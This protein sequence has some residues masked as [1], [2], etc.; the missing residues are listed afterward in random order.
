MREWLSGLT[1]ERCK[2][3]EPRTNHLCWTTLTAKSEWIQIFFRHW[4]ISEWPTTTPPPTTTTRI[5]S[6]SN[7]FRL[8][9][10]LKVLNRKMSPRGHMLSCRDWKIG[11]KK[12]RKEKNWKVTEIDFFG[13][14][15]FFPAVE[16]R[17]FSR[18]LS[19][20]ANSD[21]K[22]NGIFLLT[23]HSEDLVKE[24]SC[25]ATSQILCSS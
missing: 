19:F 13:P 2:A 4:P 12:Y 24:C 10:G 7:L 22:P 3:T 16:F 1:R 8:T 21:F 20:E 25:W 17:F 23:W 11:E 9:V 14:K 6:K 5:R 18:S 15:F